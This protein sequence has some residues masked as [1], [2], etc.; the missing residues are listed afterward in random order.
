MG[1]KEG[2]T[3]IWKQERN[4]PTDRKI[5]QAISGKKKTS[6]GESKKEK[7][8]R[9]KIARK[10]SVEVNVAIKKKCTEKDAVAEIAAMEKKV[11]DEFTAAT[12]TKTGVTVAVTRDIEDD[13]DGN[14]DTCNVGWTAK[15]TAATPLPADDIDEVA[16]KVQDETEKAT[17]KGRRLFLLVTEVSAAGGIDINDSEDVTDD[18]VNTPELSPGPDGLGPGMIVV[19]VI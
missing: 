8:Q 2:Q 3:E 10:Q 5:R 19:I 9:I 18:E 7:P 14:S 12:K 1:G 15:F 6:S 17:K 16:E 11:K 13:E 4:E